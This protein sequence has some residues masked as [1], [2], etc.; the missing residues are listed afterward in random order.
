MK[1][2]T[3][4]VL[5]V[6]ATLLLIIVPLPQ[7][8]KLYRPPFMLLFFLYM[9]LFLPHTFKLRWLFWGGICMDVLMFSAMGLHI[10]SLLVT[11]WLVSTKKRQ[12]GFSPAFQQLLFI[13]LFCI[14]Y[15]LII[16]VLNH[17]FGYHVDVFYALIQAFTGV[18]VWPWFKLILDRILMVDDPSMA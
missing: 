15:Q 8:I 11:S 4:L 18:L 5:I 16:L 14:V 3:R 12:F 17:F 9:Q 1:Q 13:A 6:L 7:P 2:P 10:F